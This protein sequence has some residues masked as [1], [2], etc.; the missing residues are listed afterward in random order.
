MAALTA[1]PA[2]RGRTTAKRRGAETQRIFADYLRVTGWPYAE[3]VGAGAQ[4]ADITGTP[5]L[6]F[7]VK[8]RAGFE[9]LSAMRQA[10]SYAGARLPLVVLRMNGQGPAAVGDWLVIMR[11][12]DAQHVLRAAGYG[13][14]LAAGETP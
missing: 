11:A 6:A 10:V 3:P 14:P 13:E 7:E 5:G 8:G 9:P 12:S 2:R 4:G 1:P